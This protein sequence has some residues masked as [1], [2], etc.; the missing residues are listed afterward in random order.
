MHGRDL[1]KE[2]LIWRVGDSSAIDV[3]NHN[4]IPRS[5]LK[6]PFGHR[7]GVQVAK[8]SE[9]LEPNRN[10]WDQNKLSDCFFEVDV[11]DIMKIPVGRAGSADYMAWNYTKNEILTV[12][13]AYHLKRQIRSSQLG[14]ASSSYNLDMHQG[15]RA[16]WLS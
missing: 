10:G 4:W 2:G 15:W 11:A 8:V 3:W 1:L 5:T 16:L 9:L 6:R 14:R 7:P 13:S 12:R